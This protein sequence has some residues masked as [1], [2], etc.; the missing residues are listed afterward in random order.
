M[1]HHFSFSPQQYSEPAISIARLLVSKIESLEAVTQ[2]IRAQLLSVRMEDV[3]ELPRLKEMLGACMDRGT[4]V[5]LLVT[6]PNGTVKLALPV[7]YR[8]ATAEIMRIQGLRGVVV[9]AA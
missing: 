6:I 7:T 5:E 2:G 3:S 1:I 4:K 8:V 9:E